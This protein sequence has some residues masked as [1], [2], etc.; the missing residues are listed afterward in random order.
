MGTPRYRE[1]DASPTVP[2]SYASGYYSGGGWVPLGGPTYGSSL[3][4]YRE[5][6]YDSTGPGPPFTEP[7]ALLLEK[8]KCIP[9]RF[10]GEARLSGFNWRIHSGYNPTNWTHFSYVDTSGA[11]DWNYWKAKALASINPFT[12]QVDLPLF[13]FELKDFPRMLRGLGYVLSGTYKARDTPGGYLAYNFGWGPLLSDLAT[14]ANFADL[15][16]KTR[17]AL[18]NA[19]NGGRVSHTLG[20]KSSPGS[21]GIYE[22]GLGGDGVYRLATTTSITQKAWCTA[23]VH[24]TEPLPFPTF[25]REMLVLKTALGLNLSAA[26]IWNA[27]PWSWLIDY[28]TNIGALME[29]RR[30]YTQWYF[31]DLHVMVKSTRTTK[32]AGTLNQVRSMSYSGG[33]KIFTRKERS[34]VGSNPDVGIGFA[35]MLNWRQTATLGALLTASSLRMAR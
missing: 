1:R 31:K 3:P 32:I 23:R 5:I 27:V 16:G 14:L 15:F 2:G 7:H 19:A 20:S 6:C 11:T 12:P 29:A 33:E 10:Y 25:E 4:S 28:F 18:T 34:Y 30:G 17:N 13:F 26:A 22:Y 24:L 9:L 8:R 35:P 21:A